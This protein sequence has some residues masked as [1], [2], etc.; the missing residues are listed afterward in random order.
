MANDAQ[1]ML[2]VT[3]GMRDYLKEAKSVF[4]SMINKDT[5]RM[6]D[7]VYKSLAITKHKLK[8]ATGN[9][10]DALRFFFLEFEVESQKSNGDPEDQFN[11][12]VKSFNQAIELLDEIAAYS[13]FNGYV[14]ENS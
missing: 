4:E 12:A 3:I 7:R 8:M 2:K 10:K 6:E 11:A 13:F 9:Y 5:I 14:R 1:N